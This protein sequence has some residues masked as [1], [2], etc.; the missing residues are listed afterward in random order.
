MTFK[1]LITLLV[2]LSVCIQSSMLM[3]DQEKLRGKVLKFSGDVEVL[4]A[5]GETR[6][7]KQADEPLNEMDTNQERGSNRRAIR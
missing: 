5:E 3:A 7:I 6:V 1:K 2:G 4:N